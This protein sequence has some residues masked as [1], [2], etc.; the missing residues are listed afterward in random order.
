[1]C[2]SSSRQSHVLVRRANHPL[3]IVKEC[4]LTKQDK[5][6]QTRMNITNFSTKR[7]P[8]VANFLKE[9]KTNE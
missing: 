9:N 5:P 8:A 7:T 6:S 4:N 3:L 1:M 2:T